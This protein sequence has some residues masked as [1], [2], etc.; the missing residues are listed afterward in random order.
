MT[1]ASARSRARGHPSTNVRRGPGP[2][3]PPRTG[4]GTPPRPPR[5]HRRRL[6]PA[7]PVPAAPR[8]RRAGGAPAGAA[9]DERAAA[10]ADR[11]GRRWA[12]GRTGRAQPGS[13]PDRQGQTES[14]AISTA[15]LRREGR[16]IVPVTPRANR[17]TRRRPRSVAPARHQRREQ[18]RQ[19][20]TAARAGQREPGVPVACRS[21]R[22]A[23]P[24][25]SFDADV[26]TRHARR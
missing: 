22:Q 1:S 19:R 13:R 26:D 25:I 20:R 24:S 11:P 18:R 21:P 5:A 16:E 23:P 4:Q 9:Q 17:L 7:P 2:G 8:P 3:R 14:V 12:A 10:T 15:P 6:P